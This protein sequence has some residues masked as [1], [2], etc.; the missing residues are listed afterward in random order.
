MNTLART[1]TGAVLVALAAHSHAALTPIFADCD[2]GVPAWNGAGV[3][4]SAIAAQTDATH[5]NQGAPD[6]S[7][8]S[9][10]LET[11]GITGVA[12]FRASSA[13]T[14]TFSVYDLDDGLNAEAADVFVGLADALGQFDST[15]LMF[16][17][18]VTNGGDH[19][20]TAITDLTVAGLWEFI[21]VQDA[22]SVQFPNTTSTDGF[23]LDAIT[24]ANDVPEPGSLAL[25]L[26]GLGGLGF[27]ARR[28]PS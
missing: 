15:S 16:A 21:Y 20:D 4:C 5:V 6:G 9:L 25:A 8:Y 2:P 11:M 18:T 1:L 28:R 17:G 12:V 26:L 10:G 24:F 23:D 22:S 13:F 27:T 14:G 19:P 7:A 3:A